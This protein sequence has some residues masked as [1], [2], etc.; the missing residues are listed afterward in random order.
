MSWWYVKLT[1]CF[2]GYSKTWEATQLALAYSVTK[3]ARRLFAFFVKKALWVMGQ[4]AVHKVNIRCRMVEPQHAIEKPFLLWYD[5]ASLGNR[6]P[7]FGERYCLTLNGPN[8]GIFL[9]ILTFEDEDSTLLGK[10]GIRLSSSVRRYQNGIL[11]Y[12]AVRTW[13]LT[14]LLS[15]IQESLGSNHRQITNYHYFSHSIKISVGYY[16][17][18]WHDW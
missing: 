15:Y 7:T 8:V 17:K 10:V 3:V 16:L 6:I 5:A 13:K 1:K 11:S 4:F 9:E 2:S 18:M 12:T 14:A